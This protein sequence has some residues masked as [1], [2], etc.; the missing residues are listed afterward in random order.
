MLWQDGRRHSFTNTA[1]LVDVVG[2]RY[3]PSGLRTAG[4][5]G[6]AW[7]ETKT[8]LVHSTLRGCS[9]VDVP[10]GTGKFKS[11]VVQ[12]SGT[13]WL[14]AE[15]ALLRWTG[16]KL[17]A[18]PNPPNTTGWQV[19]WLQAGSGQTCWMEAN[20]RL[21]ATTGDQWKPVPTAWPPSQGTR[22]RSIDANS[23]LWYA[24]AHG[25]LFAL[26]MDGNAV[27]LNGLSGLKGGDVTALFGDREGNMWAGIERVGMVQFKQ[28]RF[29]SLTLSD[30]LPAPMVWSVCELRLTAVMV[31]PRG[32][33]QAV[34]SPAC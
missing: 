4:V 1:G 12:S 7:W 9:R 32:R 29:Q 25:G 26:T 3:P 16:E 34:S 20:G 13:A 15:K 28:Q 8:G 27:P 6:E 21:W 18:V 31:C 17:I 22:E 2:E 10:P 5:G 23:N 11:L 19:Q 33:C 14:G 30:G 24:D